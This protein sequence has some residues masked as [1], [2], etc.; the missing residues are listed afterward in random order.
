MRSIG[1]DPAILGNLN[2][3][4]SIGSKEN[5]YGGPDLELNSTI[6]YG[7]Y[8]DGSDYGSYEDGYKGYLI[9]KCEK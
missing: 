3:P 8:E 2:F 6:D 7:S 5:I 1:W 9:M 4:D